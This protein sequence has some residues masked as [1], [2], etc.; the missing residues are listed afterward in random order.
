MLRRLAFLLVLLAPSVAFG[1]GA[2][3][4]QG[5]VLQGH[6]AMWLSNGYIADAG[7]P[8]GTGLAPI[9]PVSGL[10][11]LGFASV[12]SGLGTCQFSNYAATPYSSLC[13]GFDGS[14]NGLITLANSSGSTPSFTIKIGNTSYPFPGAG[15]GN[16]VGPTSPFPTAGDAVLWNGGTTVVD[17][18][19]PPVNAALFA[20]GK[21]LSGLGSG[22]YHARYLDQGV[23]IMD[24][25][26]V[27]DPNVCS[28]SDDSGPLVAA[29]ATGLNVTLPGGVTCNFNTQAGGAV[30]NL[31]TP[32]QC[33][34]GSGKGN[35][36]VATT[37]STG[38]VFE[39]TGN[40]ACVIGLSVNAP[41][42]TDGFLILDNNDQNALVADINIISVAGFIAVQPASGEIVIDN[43]RGSV[44]RGGTANI[45]DAAIP[46]GERAFVLG[47]GTTG[48][49]GPIIGSRWIIGADAGNV[50]AG[51]ISGTTLTVTAV[52]N[53]GVS[54]I[55]HL[56]PGQ[57]VFG[58]GGVVTAG[59]SILS[60]ASGTTGGVGT[61]VVSASQSVAATEMAANPVAAIDLDGDS[62]SSVFHSVRIN[63]FDTCILLTN[64]IGASGNVPDFTE[65]FDVQCQ[66]P[67]A[68]LV[69]GAGFDFNSGTQIQ[70][71]EEF[72][73]NVGHAASAAG[74]I[75][76]DGIYCGVNCTDLQIFGPRMNSMSGNGINVAGSQVG[77]YGGTVENAGN[78]STCS[79]CANLKVQ[80]GATAVRFY[81]ITQLG[82][83][84]ANDLTVGSSASD[85]KANGLVWGASTPV[86]DPGNVVTVSPPFQG[87]GVSA[88]GFNCFTP[89]L[90]YA[91]PG[92]VVFTC[93]T[94]Y[95]EWWRNGAFISFE[96]RLAGCAGNSGSGESGNLTI[97]GLPVTATGGV[98]GLGSLAVQQYSKVTLDSG[99]TQVTAQ[100]NNG[101]AQILLYENGSTEAAAALGATNVAPS[102][103]AV[104]FD[105]GGT[106]LTN[107]N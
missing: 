20:Q 89:V 25:P 86:K 78:G 73:N 19:F 2:V 50:F 27:G 30:V 58:S 52:L 105:I 104:Q 26:T 38:T 75:T 32:G 24:F 80:N 6:D 53:G 36:T 11:P 95:G 68:T 96:M 54:H 59:T 47:Y 101:N 66:T 14:G 87:C 43:I 22:T 7:G 79:T 28:G 56:A 13:T 100:M 44:V 17:A 41:N 21:V 77:V 29:A 60:Q 37:I 71:H 12:N 83:S 61:Y 69:D 16:V 15:N 8:L 81:G 46:V 85:V 1:Q 48:N 35:T 94:A 67:S 103:T 76:G 102:A 5:G 10:L 99:Y 39:L 33:I 72:A 82:G 40:N 55:G 84:A 65:G 18:G 70:L 74:N 62:N 92:S 45:Y 51:S 9:N 3:L 91:T 4:Q 57:Y 49:A 97:S 34:I 64:R 106:Y 88:T 42:M 31:T 107:T 23:S 90:T 93:S 98:M 63:N